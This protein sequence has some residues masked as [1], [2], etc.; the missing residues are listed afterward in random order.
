MTDPSNPY[1]YP[2]PTDRPRLTNAE[3]LLK[4]L[5]S[6]LNPGP[7]PN[8][9]TH[10]NPTGMRVGLWSDIHRQD[11]AR[12]QAEAIRAK[13][14][15]IRRPVSMGDYIYTVRCA[16]MEVVPMKPR[17]QRKPHPRARPRLSILN[18]PLPKPDP[19]DNPPDHP[20][21]QPKEVLR[22]KVVRME[23]IAST[24]AEAVSMAQFRLRQMQYKG[25]IKNPILH[26]GAT[27]TIAKMRS[28][29]G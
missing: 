6:N 11:K 23:V 25:D 20:D 14:E 8:P 7:G 28:V 16:Y 29:R 18:T 27:Y 24:A 5:P 13:Q 9:G 3:E 21:N 10:G 22:R 17:S 19:S 2:D 26:A 12:A 4:T 15:A 1:P